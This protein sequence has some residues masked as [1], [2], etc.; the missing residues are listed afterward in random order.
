MVNIIVRCK[1]VLSI[2]MDIAAFLN[3]VVAL[4]IQAFTLFLQFLIALFT[5]FIN[6]LSGL[7]NLL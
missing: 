7:L 2:H 5:L 4:A 6:F 3:N 1:V